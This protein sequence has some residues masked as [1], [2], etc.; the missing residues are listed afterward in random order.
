M[1]PI[2]RNHRG[3]RLIRSLGRLPAP[4][5]PCS[6]WRP[7]RLQAGPIPARSPSIDQPRALALWTTVRP[8]SSIPSPGHVRNR[9]VMGAAGAIAAIRPSPA[10]VPDAWNHRVRGAEGT[11][12]GGAERPLRRRA[13]V[14]AASRRCRGDSPTKRN[15]RAMC[16]PISPARNVLIEGY[17]ARRQSSCIVGRLSV[18]NAPAVR[19]RIAKP[20]VTRTTI[21]KSST[22][23][24]PSLAERSSRLVLM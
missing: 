24:A 13:D 7:S 16:P 3:D 15:R 23:L 22:L 8:V 5:I 12:H 4:T 17:Q 6:I 2:K 19:P 1:V 20:S 10:V 21:V 9:Q 11:S 14:A 18:P